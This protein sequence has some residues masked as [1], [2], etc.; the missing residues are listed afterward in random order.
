MLN[1]TDGNH[2]MGLF[3]IIATIKLQ[4]LFFIALQILGLSYAAQKYAFSLLATE[5]LCIAALT[6]NS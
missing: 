6:Q 4:S 5:A 3:T 2:F 1:L